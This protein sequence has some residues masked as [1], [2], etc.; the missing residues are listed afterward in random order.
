MEKTFSYPLNYR[1][2]IVRIKFIYLNFL[3]SIL[4]FYGSVENST[5]MLLKVL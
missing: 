2:I 3:K 1:Y 5:Y 4:L